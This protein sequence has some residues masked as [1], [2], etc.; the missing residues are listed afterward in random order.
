M[1]DPN[2][3]QQILNAQK[4]RKRHG[5]TG[6]WGL[7]VPQAPAVPTGPQTFAVEDIPAAKAP[8]AAVPQVAAAAPAP[9]APMDEQNP[10]AMSAVAQASMGLAGL[11]DEQA[12]LQQRLADADSYRNTPEPEA[13]QGGGLYTAANPLE[14]AGVALKQYK[15]M[16][17]RGKE[18]VVDESGNITTPGTGILEDLRKGRSDRKANLGSMIDVLR[19]MSKKKNKNAGSDDDINRAIQGSY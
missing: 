17:E 8:A 5:A 6:S 2:V 1:I 3:M 15:G 19:N 14:F 16:K 12:A 9:A 11:D 4:L 10:E 18:A 7:P 13:K